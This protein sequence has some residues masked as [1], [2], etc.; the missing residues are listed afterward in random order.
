[1]YLNSN[2]LCHLIMYGDTVRVTLRQI[3]VIELFLM[4]TYYYKICTGKLSQRRKP[5]KCPLIYHLP[6]HISGFFSQIFAKLK[7]LS[8]IK[9]GFAKKQDFS[10]QLKRNSKFPPSK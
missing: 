5:S 9:G 8:K 10:S 2:C 3:C 6:L 1:M 4:L 7:K